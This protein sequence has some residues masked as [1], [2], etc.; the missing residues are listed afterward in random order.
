MSRRTNFSIEKDERFTNI[1]TETQTVVDKLTVG[2]LID[3]SGM[4]FD[5]Q[6]T[7][8]FDP[9]ATDK[10][11][12]WVSAG[13][14]NT[15]F[16]T[17]DAGTD[18]DILAAAV[19]V[20]GGANV[21]VGGVGVFDALAGTTMNFRN[22]NDAGSGRI[23]VA[24]DG[25]NDEVDLDV[26]EASL[27][28]ASIGGSLDLTSQ[29][30]GTLPVANGGTGAAAPLTNDRVIVSSAGA[31]AETAALTDG[32]LVIGST[33][34]A[35]VVA[36]LSAGD[37]I[38]VTNAAGSITLA[39]DLKTLGGIAIE[40]TELA[41]SLSDTAITG[42]LAVGDGGTGATTLT[43]GGIV[44]GSGTGPVTVTAQPTNGQL[45]VGSTGSDPVL[46]TLTG[47]DGMDVTN[48]AGSITLAADV[49][50]DSG[51]I[52]DGASALA[53]DLSASAIVGTLAVADGGTGAATHTLNNILT[54]N[55]TS[56]VQSSGVVVDGSQNIT[57][58]LS[59]EGQSGGPLAI[60]TLG[61]QNITL[62]PNGA[63]IVR[64]NADLD[65]TGTTTTINSANL[66]V[67]DNHI[68]LNKNY[69]STG[70]QDGG[71][72][73]VNSAV[74][75]AG[76][77][78]GSAFASTTTVDVD[79][80]ASFATNDLIVISGANNVDNDG[81]YEVASVTATT[82]TIESV[83]DTSVTNI[84][85]SAFV[86]DATIAGSIIKANLS[87]IRTGV[88]GEW[89][90]GVSSTAPV[91]YNDI[92]TSGGTGTISLTTQVSGILPVANGGTN[93]SAALNNDRVMVSSAGSVVEAAALTNGQ[94]LIGSTGAAPAVGSITAGDGLD[95]ALGAGTITLA[96]D[97]KTLG[98]IAIEGTE[99]A[100]S[101]S[102]TAI[103]GT[104]AV[105]DGGTGA[106]TLTDGGIILGSGTGPVTV[107]AQPTNGQLLVGST[108]SD[109]VL[110][111]LTGGDGMDVTNAA[112]SITLAA[113][114]ETNGGI[115]ITGG[116]E[117]SLDLG[118]SA[119][120]GILAP[121]D[122]GL[123]LDASATT[124]AVSF[125]AGTAS[126]GTLSV[127][128][129]GTGATTLTDGGIVLGSGT[130]AVTV[131]AQPTNGQIL[132]GSTGV[133]PVLAT[134][135]AGDGMDVT[136]AAGSITL[137]ADLTANGGIVFDTGE[138]KL[139][140][141]GSAII[142]NLAVANGGTGVGTLTDGG[143]LLGSG[144]GPIT[145]TAQP[146]NGQLLIGSTGVDPVL[147]TLT[148]GSNI[149]IVN[150]A[151]T[152]TINNTAASANIAYQLVNNQVDVGDTTYTTI[153]HFTWDDSRYSG[154]TSGVLIFELDQTGVTAGN[155]LDIRLRAT[156]G[157]DA[158]TDLGA[159]T[160]AG[161]ATAITFENLSL[162]DGGGLSGDNRVELQV[163][164][165]SGGTGNPQI[166]GVTM[167]W[168][169]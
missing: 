66:L 149:G 86:T 4:V 122:G 156:V 45:L 152:I 144:T 103:T 165:G 75:A 89:E 3:P 42:T 150:A 15:L 43:D 8:P 93:S 47:G 2:G 119:I 90:I 132:V 18:F 166:Y 164:R 44:L 83:V 102:D 85:K 5:E 143:I 105:G 61:G 55:G 69:T 36:A 67:E 115:V 63:G 21:G 131:T 157:A 7:R 95:I 48:A 6:T 88:A 116:G 49:T 1:I 99:L 97:L 98:G 84:A 109:P 32:Q 128:N 118:A 158:G 17:N 30:I 12:L 78:N 59:I 13:A 73:V 72:C 71:V 146:T 108:G 20:T 22:I 68:L 130:G 65:V 25:V 112:G 107:T 96:A 19:G 29:V 135:T 151:G 155:E 35:P 28:L 121:V 154:Y 60:T 145:Q 37:G 147:A 138:M 134:I 34:A 58:V 62:T 16:Y 11:L 120:T 91:T 77:I 137:A 81:I 106:I 162:T 41:L 94:L 127:A 51:I 31:F 82:I 74:F 129:G 14:P 161:T 114:V 54:G 26:D 39:A 56:A 64:I 87:I 92:I 169:T 148:A 133:D 24:L 111:T 79:N 168:T 124:G 160:G 10:G 80:A 50:A 101:L 117:L 110:T 40:G 136:N 167:Q 27:N 38:D 23:T 142:G 159:D 46:A 141:D 123:G 126:V 113:D 125:A 104:L 53:L 139:D 9:T 76:T 153:A 52:I 33:G 100:L 70:V 57:N 140:M 163:R